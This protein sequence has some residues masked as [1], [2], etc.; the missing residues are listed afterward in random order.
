MLRKENTRKKKI[1]KINIYER[2]STS[3]LFHGLG[4]V[5][6]NQF[7]KFVMWYKVMWSAP[8]KSCNSVES[9]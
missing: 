2:D 6:P 9:Y 7:I 4:K 1:I 3:S 8:N 5:D